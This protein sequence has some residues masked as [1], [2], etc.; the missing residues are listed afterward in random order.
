MA[1]QN[2]EINNSNQD[3]PQLEAVGADHIIQLNPLLNKRSK[4]TSSSTKS[5]TV[6]VYS[7]EADLSVDTLAYQLSDLIHNGHEDGPI[8]ASCM[9]K[10]AAA[11][12]TGYQAMR[13]LLSANPRRCCCSDQSLE[14]SK[15]QFGWCY[16]KKGNAKHGSARGTQPDNFIACQDRYLLLNTHVN[17]L[18]VLVKDDQSAGTVMQRV[19][20]LDTALQ[21]LHGILLRFLSLAIFVYLPRSCQQDDSKEIQNYLIH[22]R[23]MKKVAGYLKGSF[24]VYWTVDVLWLY[25]Y[26][27]SFQFS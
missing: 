4:I 18:P 23:N 15:R 11:L 12:K 27:S 16:T 22:S 21:S 3:N 2:K 5:Q 6:Y 17:M 20:R 7:V 14:A 19:L 13:G 8:R 1:F 10:M 26:Y 9:G 25:D 24:L